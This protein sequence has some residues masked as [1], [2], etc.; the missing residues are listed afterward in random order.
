MQQTGVALACILIAIL[1]ACLLLSPAYVGD[2]RWLIFALPVLLMVMREIYDHVPGTLS[3]PGRQRTMLAI[4]PLDEEDDSVDGDDETASSSIA[5]LWSGSATIWPGTPDDTLQILPITLMISDA[6][7][8]ATL[9]P[10]GTCN[11]EARIVRA[12]VLEYDTTTGN[13]DLALVVASN[14]Q[15]RS[16]DAKLILTPHAMLP[17][18]KTDP[19]TVELKRA[20]FTS[21]I[22]ATAQH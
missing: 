7:P 13:V 16:F 9:I 18:D 15:Q 17:A 1:V 10:V 5:G 14:D 20:T 12:R 4:E 21:V 19:V 8:D 22:P 2:Y 11:A 3:Q 6:D